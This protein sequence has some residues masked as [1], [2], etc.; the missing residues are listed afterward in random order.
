MNKDYL[1]KHIDEFKRQ[2]D[3]LST[4]IDDEDIATMEQMM[5]ESRKRYHDLHSLDMSE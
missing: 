1:Q 5:V 2:L 4:A 3:K